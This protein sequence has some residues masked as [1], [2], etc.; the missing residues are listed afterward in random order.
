M[1]E[2]YVVLVSV[3]VFTTLAIDPTTTILPTS[4]IPPIHRHRECLFNLLWRT[5]YP[6]LDDPSDLYPDFQSKWDFLD[7]DCTITDTTCF[8]KENAKIID[9][10]GVQLIATST[11]AAALVTHIDWIATNQTNVWNNHAITRLHMNTTLPL[12]VRNDHFISY[13]LNRTDCRMLIQMS[14]FPRQ[15]TPSI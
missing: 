11:S 5:D 14:P 4:T 3:C 6:H 2:W 12:N 1:I 9:H 15:L 13:I 10:Q 7:T 8:K